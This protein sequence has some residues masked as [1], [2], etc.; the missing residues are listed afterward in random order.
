M[1]TVCS[2]SLRQ[3]V[4]GKS[5]LTA[6]HPWLRLANT[7]WYVLAQMMTA[8]TGP[9]GA[10]AVAT[11]TTATTATTKA[12]QTITIAAQQQDSEAALSP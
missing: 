6:A 1:L 8:M 12:T 5:A 11:T 2:S 3:R 4:R 9:T 7:N 10:A